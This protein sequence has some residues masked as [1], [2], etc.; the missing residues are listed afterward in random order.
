VYVVYNANTGEKMEITMEDDSI[1]TEAA[2]F[3]KYE[4][5]AEE[6]L[7]ELFTGEGEAITTGNA[8][9]DQSF[10]SWYNNMLV[11]DDIV[12]FDTTNAVIIDTRSEDE[13][14]DSEIEAVEDFEDLRF[15]VDEN[16]ENATVIID[17]WTDNAEDEVKVIFV[18]TIIVPEEEA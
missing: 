17:V 7:Y 12:N 18:K 5:D 2:G 4:Y 8:Y 13:I 10:K 3:Y 15:L 1:G 11:T 14:E 9:I 16:G 6:N